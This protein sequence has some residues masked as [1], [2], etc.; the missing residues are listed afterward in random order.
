M[1]IGKFLFLLR[2]PKARASTMNSIN[3]RITQIIED[4][5][6]IKL[7]KY[8]LLLLSLLLFINTF[9]LAHDASDEL[10][11]KLNKIKSMAAT[12]EQFSSSN[13]SL[14][15]KFKTTGKMLLHRPS[16]FRW[17][18]FSPDRQ[19]IIIN[20]EEL[21]IYNQELEQVTL[22]KINPND[23]STPA[24]I[25]SS[26]GNTLKQFFNITKNITKNI[27]TFV[28]TPIDKK[29]NHQRLK[30]H[31]KDQI[32]I[33]ITTKNSLDQEFS[34]TFSNIQTNTKI[35]SKNFNF[36]LPSTVDISDERI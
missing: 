22:R 12:F 13:S 9:S 31:F 28:L 4:L 8:P 18:I 7:L 17:E 33:G 27:S 23:L 21:I 24:F 2:L 10:M 5:S 32:L 35:N 11:I 29:S 1:G 3:F 20:N 30:L 6:M 15:N 25:I 19:L 14:K 16:Q 34:I 26:T 36:T